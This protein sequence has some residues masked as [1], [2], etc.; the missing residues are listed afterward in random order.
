MNAWI[1]T[2]EAG[3]FFDLEEDDDDGDM[4]LV[5]QVREMLELVNYL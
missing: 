2:L 5:V 1:A 4:I 3:E